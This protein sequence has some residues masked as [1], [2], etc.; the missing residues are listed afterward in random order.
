MLKLMKQAFSQSQL[1]ISLLTVG[2]SVC[3]SLD[4]IVRDRDRSLQ[5]KRENPG[6]FSLAAGNGALRIPCELEK[7]HVF[8][9]GRIDHSEPLRIGLDTGAGVSLLD[10]SREKLLGSRIEQGHLTVGC[11]GPVKSGVIRGITVSLPGVELFNQSLMTLPLGSVQ[12]SDAQRMDA[13][14]GHD[15]FRRLVV[16]IDYGSRLISLYDPHGYQYR[17]P[18]E[19]LPIKIRD[20]H[21]YVTAKLVIQGHAPI[22]G[23]FVIDTGSGLAL[24][25]QSAFVEEHKLLS[26]AHRILDLR[27]ECVGGSIP[28]PTGR[29]KGLL[30]GRFVIDSP[31]AVFAKSGEF[32]APGSAGNIGG[33]ILSRFKVIVDYSRQ[34]LIMEPNDHFYEQ[35]E[36]DMS[37]I[38]LGSEGPRSTVIKV[39]RILEPS[40]AAEVGLREGDVIVAVNHRPAAELSLDT[41]DEM[42]RHD[43][44]EYQLTVRRG[45]ALLEF[46]LKLRRLI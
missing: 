27:G 32:A 26:S 38:T 21:P 34:R 8:L 13:I 20:N 2:L 30:L 29:V 42:L 4:A 17:G 3:G 23:Q 33:M 31:L 1:T 14:L 41:L 36:S 24:I 18:G 10:A 35:Y 16:E 7:N 12:S 37:G 22:E 9:R 46:K 28:L 11:A 40:P 45:D 44:R 19:I 15:L 25:L 5:T 43:G 6:G 39:R